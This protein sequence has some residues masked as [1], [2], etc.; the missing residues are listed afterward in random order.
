MTSDA[1]VELPRLVGEMGLQPISVGPLP[2]PVRG[3]I[4]AMGEYERLAAEAAVTG[5][6]RTTLGALLS[7]LFVRSAAVAE[8]ILDEVLAAHR[9]LLPQ[10]RSWRGALT[11]ET[12]GCGPNS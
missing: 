2:P 7:H 4:Q 3:L 9:D 12:T 8:A 10:F 1:I 5:D 6:R 11:I